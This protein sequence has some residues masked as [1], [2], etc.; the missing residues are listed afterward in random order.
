MAGR[1]T[2]KQKPAAP[3]P[4]P[5]HTAFVIVNETSVKCGDVLFCSSSI[6]TKLTSFQKVY[7]S[8]HGERQR[9]K[10]KSTASPSNVPS[11]CNQG[12]EQCTQVLVPRYSKI[13]IPCSVDLTCS[14]RYVSRDQIISGEVPQKHVDR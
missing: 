8:T 2:P 7:M 12:R 4:A 9:E 14:I 5:R 11:V 13:D 3:G 6:L 10:F 1:K